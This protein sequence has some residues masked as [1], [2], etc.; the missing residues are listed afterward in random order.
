MTNFVYVVLILFLSLTKIN[1]LY[2]TASVK[3]CLSI[4]VV[5]G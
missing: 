5:C 3:G 2:R 4:F 1:L